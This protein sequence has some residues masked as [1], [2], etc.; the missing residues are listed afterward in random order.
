MIALPPALGGPARLTAWR[1]DAEQFRDRWD[2]GEGGRL[3][4]GRWNSPGI[5]AVYLSLDPSTAILEVA[6]HKGIATLARM[7]HVM[8]AV[9]I[10]DPSTVHVVQ[11]EEVPEPAWLRPG[12]PTAAQ[13]AHGDQRLAAHPFVLWPSTVSRHSWNL[14]WHLATAEG[15]Y[16]VVLQE[17]L[18]LDPRLKDVA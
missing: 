16:R 14:V 11:P 5:A 2:R 18:V 1:I 9:A 8:T 3:Y 17:A 7:P 15:R 6:V 13:Q 4:G 10:D 12:W